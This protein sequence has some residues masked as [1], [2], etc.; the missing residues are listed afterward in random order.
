MESIPTPEELTREQKAGQ[1]LFARGPQLFAAE[2]RRMLEDGLIGG[3]VS[4]L[5]GV[6]LWAIT[7]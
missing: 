2:T 6:V 1:L 3:L 4:L 7:L 5:G